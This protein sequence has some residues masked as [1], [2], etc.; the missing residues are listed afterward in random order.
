LFDCDNSVRAL[1]GIDDCR[2]VERPQSTQVD[3][4]C[5]D[6]LGGKLLRSLEYE[7]DANRMRHQRYILARFHDARLADGYDKVLEF[8][9]RERAPIRNLVLEKNHRIRIAD[10][11]FEET[12]CIGRE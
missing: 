3:E 12:L 7:A 11:S 2:G 6:T 9:H 5:V 4:F 1:H 10:G 8:G